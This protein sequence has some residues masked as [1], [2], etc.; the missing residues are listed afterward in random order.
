M[1]FDPISSHAVHASIRRVLDLSGSTQLSDLN[2]NVDEQRRWYIDRIFFV[3]NDVEQ[4]L[5]EIKPL[6]A[7]LN[8]MG[9]IVNSTDIIHQELQNF[10]SN[11]N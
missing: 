1:A 7:N 8:T 4:I 10:I 2:D 6:E 11:C 5:S 3:V 9:S